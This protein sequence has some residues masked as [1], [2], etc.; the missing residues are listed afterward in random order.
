M[1]RFGRHTQRTFPISGIFLGVIVWSI[2]FLATVINTPRAHAG[3]F[4]PGQTTFPALP[5]GQTSAPVAI[6]LTAQSTGTATVFAALTEGVGTAGLAE[7]SVTSPGSCG[8]SLNPGQSCTLTVTFTPRYPG[9]R[10]GGILLETSGGQLLAG[11]LVSGQGQGGLPVLVPGQI[12]TVAGDGQWFFEGDGG[13]ATGAPIYLPSGLAVDGAGNLY[14]ADTINNRVR[15]VDAISH[16]IT[17]VAGTGNAGLQGDNGPATLAEIAQP[18]GLALDGAGNLYIADAGNSAV[19]RVDAVSGTITTVAGMLG[20]AG[21]TGDNGPAMSAKLDNPQG[22]ALTASGDLLIADTSNA[23]VRVV[24]VADGQIQ[25]IAGTGTAGY[26]GDGVLATAAELNEPSSIAVR[27]DGAIA[28]ADLGNNRV[29]L[30]TAGGTIDTIA[31]NGTLGYSGDSGPATQAELQGPAAVTFDPAGDLFIADSVNN[32]IRMVFGPEATIITLSGVPSDDRYA[33]DGGPENQARMHGPDGLLFDGQGN[34][35]LS[36]RFNNRVREISGSSLTIGPYPTMKVGKVSQPVAETMMNAGNQPLTFTSP[37][38]QQAALNVLVTTCGAGSLAPSVFCNMGVE[39]SPTNI[40]SSIDGSITWNSNVPN[41]TPVDQ[42][43]GQVLSVEP[44][45]TLIT[46]SAN[47]GLL[48]SSVTLTAAVTSDDTSRT[49]TVDFVEG[50]QT[51]C[52]SVPVGVGGTAVCQ[53]PSLSLGSHSFIANYS[54]DGNNAASQSPVFVETVKQSASLNLT[55]SSTSTTVTSNVVLTLNGMDLY[56]GTTPTGNVVFYDGQAALGTSTLVSG[57]AA[58]PISDFSVGT[59]SLSAQYSGDGSNV[60][61]SSNTVALVV[62]KYST[63]TLLSSANNRATVGSSVAL[64]AT[65][66]NGSGPA[67]MG[68]V[69]FFDGTT[70]LGSGL[71]NGNST[72]LLSISTLSPGNHVLTAVYSGDADNDASTSAPI[73]EV[74]QQI[75]TGT[76]LSPDVNPL[77]AGAVLHLQAITTL[78][79]GAAAYGLLSGIVTFRDGST[80]LGSAPLNNNGQAMLT[81]NFLSVG[82]HAITA[83]FSGNTNYA[84]SDSPTLSE[85]VQQTST[86]TLLSSVSTTTLMGEPVTL[87]IN[88]ASATGTPTGSVTLKENGRVLGVASLSFTGNA[89]YSTSGLGAGVHTISAV[90][91]GDANYL[92]SNSPNLQQTI[93][94]AQTTLTLSGPLYAIDAGTTARFLAALSTP[95]LAPGGV[96]TLFDGALN[97]GTAPVSGSGGYSLTTSQLSVGTHRLIAQY[98]GDPNNSSTVSAGIVVIV[99]QASSHTLL[100]SS[101]NPLTIGG[102]VM[103]T[104]TVTND[105]PNEGGTVSF[106]DGSTLLGAAPLSTQGTASISPQTLAL[107]MHTLYAVYSGDA[108]HAASTSASVPEVVVRSSSISITSSANPSVSGQSVTFS[109]LVIGSPTPTG[110]VAF[111]DHGTLLASVPLNNAGFASLSTASLDVGSHVISV[112]YSGD[113]NFAAADALLNQTVLSASTQT[114]LEVS[115][116]PASYGQPLTLSASVSSNGSAAT[117]AVSFTD[118]GVTLGSSQLG[119]DGKAALTLIKL[120]PG[121]H[122]LSAVYTGSSTSSPSSSAPLAFSVKQITSIGVSSNAGPALTLSPII[123]TASLTSNG[124]VAIGGEV[125]FTDGLTVL[126]SALVNSSG[127]AVLTVPQMQ[128]GTHTVSATYAGDEANFGSHSLPF[129]QTVQLRET[130]VTVTG[131]PTDASNPQQIT[132]IAV[133]GGGNGSVMPTGTVTFTS[134]NVTLGAAPVDATGVASITVDFNTPTQRVLASYVG[135]LSY[136]ASQSSATPVT[137]GVPAQFTISLNAPTITLVSHQHTTVSVTVASVKEFTDTIALGCLGLPYAA[138]CT[139]ENSQFALASGGQV[140]VSLI[141]DTGNPLGAGSSASAFLE[142]RSLT[143]L[144]LLPAG[145]ALGRMRRKAR[146]SRLFL[147]LALLLGCLF[148]TGLSGC[149]G[150][151]VSG[152]PPGSYT[153]RVVGTGQGSNITEAQTVTLVVTP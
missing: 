96:L 65:V 112:T 109:A 79:S 125:T 50:G 67:P 102:V 75:S 3:T 62:A 87:N 26:N 49:G 42:L 110:S 32:C 43:Y 38:L 39:F 122:S 46:S 70:N 56:G 147:A 5:V 74:I 86:V 20:Q 28:I 78:P 47:P 152:T 18:S 97:L 41:I 98:S 14:L 12:S 123:L 58:L 51:W 63:S 55:L 137:A 83:V 80:V 23:A 2:V 71:L 37:L 145:V 33:G 7:F 57:S 85:S 88:V 25:T 118:A 60:S 4:T 108:D 121:M 120:A 139:F 24:T 111:Q 151:Q 131:I 126:G 53:V 73:S 45:T 61:G 72:A 128:A 9:V 82:T 10:H 93:N 141:V 36:D 124:P 8:S 13:P 35:W 77:N 89:V 129:T 103:L 21:Y 76:T 40:G 64:S 104:A 16:I 54:G 31:G 106:Y 113:S 140:T 81:L 142:H 153:F 69:Q 100:V 136:A 27:F 94:L 150:L 91:N 84:Q 6:T 144:C 105:S 148:S 30:M 149:G 134:G 99:E 44:T 48:N 130:T 17:T 116:N 59:H 22:I 19:R 52:S 135:D 114:F 90:Y 92:A 138:T 107:G 34:L 143:L 119:A 132:L 95:G 68:T 133:V 66:L 117:G 1:I 15:R 115:S 29:R 127:N 11:A 101:V 146:R